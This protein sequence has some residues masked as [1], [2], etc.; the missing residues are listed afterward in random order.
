MWV[1]GRESCRNGGEESSQKGF[2]T[3]DD[4][5][6]LLFTRED[7]EMSKMSVLCFGRLEWFC[8]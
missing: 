1:G 5:K 4:L 8:L 2:K 3:K 6:A 7:P